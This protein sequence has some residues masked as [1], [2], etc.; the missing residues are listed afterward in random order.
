M[1]TTKPQFWISD[2]KLIQSLTLRSKKRNRY[3]HHQAEYVVE[4]SKV[5]E[6]DPLW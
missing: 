2:W 5:T 4:R 6:L 3:I 1:Y